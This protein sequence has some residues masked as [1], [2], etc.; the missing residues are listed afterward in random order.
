MQSYIRWNPPSTVT[1]NDPRTG[2]PYSMR[3]DGY[4]YNCVHTLQDAYSHLNA[5]PGALTLNWH[6]GLLCPFHPDVGRKNIRCCAGRRR[7][8][9]CG[10]LLLTSRLLPQLPNVD[11]YVHC[12][13]WEYRLLDAL[14]K[15]MQDPRQMSQLPDHPRYVAAVLLD[16]AYLHSQWY[17]WQEERDRRRDRLH[18]W[19]SPL[20]PH[21]GINGYLYPS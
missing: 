8:R 21:R 20:L 14:D 11:G 9:G 15:I 19:L 17:A 13:N 10:G 3:F 16:Y 18:R 1:G 12:Y 5:D 2:A 7:P 6:D 4:W